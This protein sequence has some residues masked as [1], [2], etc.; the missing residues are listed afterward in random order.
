MTRQ[1]NFRINDVL[2]LLADGSFHSGQKLGEALGISRAAVN[3]HVHKLTEL[4]VDIYSV[5]GKGYR[6]AKPI[7]LLQ[8]QKI[9]LAANVDSHR[10]A[11][12]PVV[13]STNDDIKNDLQSM[14]LQPG[15]GLVS[16][17]Q[18]A[19]RG[20][21]GKSWHSPFGS[22]LYISIYWPLNEGI[23]RAMGLSLAVGIAVAEGLIELGMQQVGLKWPNDVYVAGHKIAGILVDIESCYD[24]SASCIVGIGL[25]VN[26]PE[27]VGEKIDQRWTDVSQQLKGQWS[28]NEIAG[29]IYRHVIKQLTLFSAEGLETLRKRWVELDIF[30]NKSVKLLM[31]ERVVKGTCRGIDENGA[32]LIESDNNVVRYFGGE[33]SLRAAT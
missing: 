29:V 11:V 18:T 16:E 8:L 4:G 13:G 32:I 9:A 12:K 5:Q 19:G 6:L 1:E 14:S 20:R 27:S 3:Q 7:E 22:N 23:N 30:I 10:I 24:G 33:I 26:M 17:A 28:R 21:R 2:E 15:Y 31:G 25:N